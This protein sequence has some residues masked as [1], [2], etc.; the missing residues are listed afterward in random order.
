MRNV[1]FKNLKEEELINVDSLI[2]FYKEY[3]KT[4]LGYNDYEIMIA[5]EDLRNPYA[6]PYINMSY[7]ADCEIGGIKYG[8]YPC[9]TDFSLCGLY[10]LA[11]VSPFEFYMLFDLSTM[12]DK[13][14]GSYLN[15]RKMFVI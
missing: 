13:T 14:V 12:P 15:A 10:H 3:L 11:D 7:L 6:T 4:K 1:N 5:S 9:Y 8:V 2:E